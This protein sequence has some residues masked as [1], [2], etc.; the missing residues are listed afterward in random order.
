MK[1]NKQNKK[2]NKIRK[3]TIETND[4]KEH[5]NKPIKC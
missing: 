2:I 4:K 5:I 3:Y 1:K